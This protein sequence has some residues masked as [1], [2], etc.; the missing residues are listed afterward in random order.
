MHVRSVK[1][2]AA[3]LQEGLDM[4]GFLLLNINLLLSKALLL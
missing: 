4:P 3:P 2:A 1:K